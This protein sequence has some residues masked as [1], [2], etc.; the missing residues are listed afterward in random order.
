[1]RFFLTQSRRGA[2]TRTPKGYPDWFNVKS[3]LRNNVGSH[4]LRVTQIT[5]LQLTRSWLAHLPRYL[6]D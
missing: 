1:M 3:H 2:S 4:P 5:W 6:P